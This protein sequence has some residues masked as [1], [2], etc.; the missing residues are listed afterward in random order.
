MRL[1]AALLGFTSTAFLCLAGAALGEEGAPPPGPPSAEFCKEN[2]GKCEEA[3]EKHAA[4]CKENPE[5]CDQLKQKRAERREFCKQNPEKCEQQ[6]AKMRER[7][8]ELKAKCEADPERCEE[9]KQQ[10]RERGK[11]RRG[12]AKGSE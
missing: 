11:A 10:A 5:K 8:D 4:W 6:R 12:G 1:R 9:M 7:R 2:P 3:R